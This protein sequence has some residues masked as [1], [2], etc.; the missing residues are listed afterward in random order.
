MTPVIAC[1]EASGKPDQWARGRS[2][3]SVLA[4]MAD[5]AK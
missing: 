4:A 3:A 5:A 1:P 2:L